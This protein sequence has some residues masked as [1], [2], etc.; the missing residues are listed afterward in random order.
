M[1]LNGLEKDQNDLKLTKMDWKF[2]LWN[3]LKRTAI[4]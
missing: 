2:G 3:K 4:D 1:D